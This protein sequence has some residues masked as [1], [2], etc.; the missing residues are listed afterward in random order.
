[1]EYFEVLLIK[2]YKKFSFTGDSVRSVFR[3]VGK[4]AGRCLLGA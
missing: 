1:M 2:R 3:C 4:A